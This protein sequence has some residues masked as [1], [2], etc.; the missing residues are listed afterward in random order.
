MNETFRLRRFY[1]DQGIAGLVVAGVTA[2]VLVSCILVWGLNG[3]QEQIILGA[4]WINVGLVGMSALSLLAYSRELLTFTGASIIK[5]G[6]LTGSLGTVEIGLAD[7]ASMT[8][9]K[10]R[11]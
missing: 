2:L 5:K 1:R 11:V 3:P 4:A 6:V 8:W 9:T 10:T 7:L